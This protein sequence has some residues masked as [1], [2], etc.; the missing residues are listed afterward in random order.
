MHRTLIVARMRPGSA[1]PIAD[2]FAKSD[3]GELPRLIGVR[4]RSLFQFGEL[5]LHLIE[6]D[7]PVGPAVAELRDHPEFRGISERLSRYVSAYDPQTW[8]EPRDAMAREFYRWDRG[9]SG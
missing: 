8:R 9:G 1:E 4:G 7:R 2:I 3:A 5:Y 6:A